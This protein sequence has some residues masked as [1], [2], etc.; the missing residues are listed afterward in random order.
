M[1]LT[2]QIILGIIQGVTEWIPISSEG[3]LL[4]VNSNFFEPIELNLFLRQALLL[5]LGTFFAALIYFR[6]EVLILTE[7]LFNYRYSDSE[8]RRTLRFLFIATLISGVLGLAILN[9]IEIIQINEMPFTSAT[10]NIVVGFFLLVTGIFQLRASNA[11]FR[12]A[13]HL[14][15]SDSIFLGILQ[16]FAVIPGLSRSGLTVSGLLFRKVND[17]TALK[18]SFI[19]SLPIVLLGN[20]FLNF[21]SFIFIKEMFFAL[22]VSFAFGLMTI[23]LL[24]EFSRKVKFGHFV[25]AFGLL[26]LAAGVFNIIF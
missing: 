3:L 25:I 9:F 19:M 26:V 15:D 16:G 11:G 6:K 17:T 20:V 2:Q 5:H 8:T 1:D 13:Y 23:H 7:G 21:N 24:M 10:V 4:F 12:R 22:I 14:K 18:L